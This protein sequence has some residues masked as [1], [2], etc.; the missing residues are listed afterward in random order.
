MG[1][2]LNPALKALEIVLENESRASGTPAEDLL[3]QQLELRAPTDDPSPL[4]P[5][6]LI[7]LTNGAEY[8]VDTQ[9]NLTQIRE[10]GG[11]DLTDRELRVRFT[12]T[13]GVAGLTSTYEADVA[14]LSDEDAERLRQ[15]IDETNFFDLPDEVSNGDPTPD[16][17]TYTL[18]IA[19]GRRNR[20]LTTYD[21][22]GPHQSPPLEKLI[23]WLKERAPGPELL[24]GNTR[25]A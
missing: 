11:A 9:G 7:R 2:R 22:S 16:Q 15:F 23:E 14:G 10:S 13:G 8:M 19:H 25:H 6:Y 24:G 17:Y 12:Q 5:A 20:E 18:W 3:V 21:G 4:P 1:Q